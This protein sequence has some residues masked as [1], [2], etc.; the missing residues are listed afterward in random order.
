M[1]ENDWTLHDT[2]HPVQGFAP[3]VAE[4]GWTLH[5]SETP[6]V[7]FSP[8]ASA[9]TYD[10]WPAPDLYLW[11]AEAAG[12]GGAVSLRMLMGIGT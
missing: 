11:T 10:F 7:G 4:G 12:G 6:L 3:G 9:W 5:E 2:M 8:S 1:A